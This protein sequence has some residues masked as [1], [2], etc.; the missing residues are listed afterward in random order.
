MTAG[1]AGAGAGG[2]GPAGQPTGLALLTVPGA[3][4]GRLVVHAVG[5]VA[6]AGLIAVALFFDGAA[7]AVFALVLGGLTAL[8][9]LQLPAA[10]QATTGLAIQGAAWASALRGYEQIWWLDIVAHLVVNGLLA[11]AAGLMLYRAGLTPGAAGRRGR[12][13]LAITTTGAGAVL[14]IVW[15]IA[16]W[17]GYAFVD[18]T[19]DVAPADTTGDLAAALIG[20]ALAGLVLARRVRPRQGADG[21]KGPR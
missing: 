20:S 18:P 15:E 2:A 10:L 3:R 7:V 16:E 12:W 17:F 14:A 5:L 6:V 11:A 9:V 4:P 21:A 19:I 13:A 1:R 8:R